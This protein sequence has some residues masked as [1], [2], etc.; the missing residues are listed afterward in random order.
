[1]QFVQSHFVDEYDPT[2]E[3]SYRKACYITGLPAE[4]SGK[5]AG[6]RTPRTTSP[7]VTVSCLASFFRSF[8]RKGGKAVSRDGGSESS[9][10]VGAERRDVAPHAP[11]KEGR[12]IMVR[13]ADPNILILQLGKLADPCQVHSGDAIRCAT[14]AAVLSSTACASS[15]QGGAGLTW[16]CSICGDRNKN[17]EATSDEVPSAPSVD[18][19]L[20]PVAPS[21]PP[22]EAA[23]S[24][25]DGLVIFCLDL[26][27]SM[28]VT[29]KVPP[30]QAEWKR[31]RGGTAPA[32]SDF[33]SRQGCLQL[34]VEKQLEYLRYT[35]PNK[36]VL[37]LTFST[38]VTVVGDGFASKRLIQGTELDGLEGLLLAG[39]EYAKTVSVRSLTESF[40]F[41]QKTVG[42]R[43]E[44][45][46]GFS[47]FS[48]ASSTSPPG[49]RPSRAIWFDSSRAMPCGGVRDCPELPAGRGRPVH[50]RAAQRRHW[51]ARCPHGQRRRTQVLQR[52]Q[53]ARGPAQHHDIR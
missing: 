7:Q 4:T 16:T 30:L 3:D 46:W 5:A 25:D 8:R 51:R 52:H 19:L 13:M 49:P 44:G 38:V 22:S 37:L 48:Q 35:H 24:S 18:Y 47:S 28:G 26:S 2:I 31:L 23:V 36:R 17:L 32:G 34:A 41:L 14:C 50:R 20:T 29:I 40:E 15:P 1:V 21:A 33:I 6:R 53:H 42:E 39:R 10:D 9:S 12:K 11:K 45:L 43:T 27:G